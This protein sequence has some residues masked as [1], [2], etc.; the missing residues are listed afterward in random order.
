MNTVEKNYI[1]KK[2]DNNRKKEWENICNDTIIIR[3]NN[4]GI[5]PIINILIESIDK[6]SFAGP[7]DEINDK[8][9]KCGLNNYLS[10]SYKQNNE[11]DIVK[12]IDDIIENN[13]NDIIYNQANNKILSETIKLKNSIIINKLKNAYENK[14]SKPLKDKNDSLSQENNINNIK[15]I[16]DKNNIENYKEKYLKKINEKNERIKKDSKYYN[17]NEI[18]NIRDIKD[19]S[20]NSERN[21][22][23]IMKKK[24]N[25]NKKYSECALISI[26]YA[27]QKYFKKLLGKNNNEIKKEVK[28]NENSI[29]SYNNIKCN[30]LDNYA[31]KNIIKPLR[32]NKS[33]NHLSSIMPISKIKKRI[34]DNNIFCNNKIIINP[35]TF[36]YSSFECIF[37]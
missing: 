37:L 26:K 14:Y 10:V 17:N 23:N 18:K 6:F 36:N 27:S 9:N 21:N 16:N 7:E 11:N 22:C 13:E 24:K 28:Y 12:Y 32:L 33:E 29:S 3:S 5:D 8:S 30:N 19:K 20:M 4:N 1:N 31:K 15:S 25:K 2:K 34:K 35:I